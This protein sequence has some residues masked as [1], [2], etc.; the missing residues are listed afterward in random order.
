MP[1]LEFHEPSYKVERADDYG[2]RTNNL[3]RDK[4]QLAR[5][6]LNI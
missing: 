4:Q 2:K 6:A 3:A 5:D 1:S